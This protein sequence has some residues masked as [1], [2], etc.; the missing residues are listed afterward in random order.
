M[1]RVEVIARFRKMSIEAV[2]QILTDVE[3]YPQWVCFVKRVRVYGT[4]EG[5]RWDDVTVIAWIPLTMR[6]T[7]ISC[8]NNKEYTLILPLYFGGHMKQEY[9]LSRDN[10]GYSLLKALITYDFGNKFL[11]NM[12]GVILNPRLRKMLETSFCNI[13]AEIV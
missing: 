12:V 2:W 5:S 10:D 6:H 3:K 13:G 11:N 8:K 1:K 4:G 7:V 9:T